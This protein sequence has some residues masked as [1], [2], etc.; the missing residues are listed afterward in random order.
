MYT[1]ALFS[2]FFGI[3]FNILEILIYSLLKKFKFG[4]KNDLYL[5]SNGSSK[6]KEKVDI[7]FINSAFSLKFDII[8]TN[9]VLTFS[10]IVKSI[11]KKELFLQFDDNK[12]Y[13]LL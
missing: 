11:K 2:Y 6:Y 12:I 3:S 7:N 1:P 5:F 9:L 8:F 4:I 13:F 10:I